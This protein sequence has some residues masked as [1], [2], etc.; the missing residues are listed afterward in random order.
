MIGL[1]IGIV[2]EDT[3]IVSNGVQESQLQII[4]E[5]VRIPYRFEGKLQLMLCNA[6]ASKLLQN[7]HIVESNMH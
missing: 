2:A 4:C 6:S 3:R 1:C 7:M 5:H